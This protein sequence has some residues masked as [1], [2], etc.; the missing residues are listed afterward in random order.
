MKSRTSRRKLLL[1][2]CLA[3]VLTILASFLATSRSTL[4]LPGDGHLLVNWIAHGPE[5]RFYGVARWEDSSRLRNGQQPGRFTVIYF[6]YHVVETS[7]PAAA[8]AAVGIAGLW[9]VGLLCF[10]GSRG[11]VE[12]TRHER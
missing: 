12:V 5:G 1:V 6:S 4:T 3:A 7:L 9:S 2:G 11:L 8:V 10:A